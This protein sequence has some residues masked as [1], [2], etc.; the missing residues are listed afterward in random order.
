ML[1]VRRFFPACL[2]MALVS[3]PAAADT[4]Q[5]ILQGKVTMADGSPPPKTASVERICSDIQG[6]APG[7]ITN[8]KGEY[9]W[10]MEVDPM[11]TRACT[12]RAHL[13]GYTSTAIDISALNSYSNQKLPP[14]VLTPTSG[15]PT[16][17]SVPED[18]VPSKAASAWKAAM[19][20]LDAGKMGE[21][22]EHMQAAVA[23]APKFA[24]GWNALGLVYGT[25]QKDAESR[26]AFQHAIAADPKLLPAYVSLA[27]VCIRTKDW[28]GAAKTA[29]ALLKADSKH[30]FPEIYL[31]QAVARYQLKDL[32]GAETS[33]QEAIKLDQSRKGSRAEYVYGRILSAKGDVAA[34]REH[35][36]K[37]LALDPNSPDVDVI[38]A[39]LQ[40]LDKPVEA[41]GV[42]PD[43]EYP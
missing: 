32:A 19:K 17:I 25:Q 9:L 30:Q 3:M 41:R 28:D 26:D 8:K 4:Y 23:A 12:L 40:N 43:L 18:A 13:A 16:V 27:R 22:G 37:Y 5:L 34:A 7:P 20:A 38:K 1:F 21:A 10:R 14:L 6:S 33:V 15:D 39:E 31:H 24:G 2:A 29:E 42:E 36:T 11:L 35:I